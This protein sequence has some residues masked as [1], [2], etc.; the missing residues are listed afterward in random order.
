M[1][2]LQFHQLIV[3]MQA[4]YHS[5]KGEVEWWRLPNGEWLGKRVKPDG[6]VEVRRFQANS[7]NC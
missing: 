2:P 7:C 6:T 4:T 3:R 1:T 5:T